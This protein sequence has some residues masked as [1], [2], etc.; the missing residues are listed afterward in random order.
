MHDWTAPQ[1]EADTTA[2]AATL[3]QLWRREPASQQQS[4]S[5]ALARLLRTAP[6]GRVGEKITPNT[7]SDTDTA[8]ENN[9]RIEVRLNGRL[10][11]K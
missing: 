3:Q 8:Y 7:K 9:G 4:E 5:R 10:L 2:E 1:D 6:C 11:G